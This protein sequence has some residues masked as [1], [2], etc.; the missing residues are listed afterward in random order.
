MSELYK[1]IAGSPIT[2]LA[3]DIDEFILGVGKKE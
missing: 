1:A 3:G 2:Y